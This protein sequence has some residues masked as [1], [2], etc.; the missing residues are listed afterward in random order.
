ME[1]LTGRQSRT[2]GHVYLP[3]VW[4]F[5]RLLDNAFTGLFGG[6]AVPMAA[7][8]EVNSDSEVCLHFARLFKIIRRLIA[9]ML[10]I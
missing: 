9:D 5:S 7:T 2:P 4:S 3:S 10:L 6:A 1:G 8:V